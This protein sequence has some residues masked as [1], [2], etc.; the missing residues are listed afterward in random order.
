M[1]FSRK[2]DNIASQYRSPFSRKWLLKFVT[3]KRMKNNIQKACFP[4]RGLLVYSRSF[5]RMSERSRNTHVFHR[6]C[7][8]M[9][10]YGIHVAL[11]RSAIFRYGQEMDFIDQNSYMKVNMFNYQNIKYYIYPY[12]LLLITSVV[13]SNDYNVRKLAFILKR[14]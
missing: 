8:R 6:N 7:T 12:S 4:H 11:P 5:S 10:R 1:K 13:W 2:S 9:P 14:L 3:I